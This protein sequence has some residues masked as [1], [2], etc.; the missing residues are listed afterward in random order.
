MMIT[1][2]LHLPGG[3]E[4]AVG[5]WRLGEVHEIQ[6]RPA[7]GG[8]ALSSRASVVRASAIAY[9]ATGHLLYSDAG[10]RPAE[11]WA[12]PISLPKVELRGEPLLVKRGAHGPSV[13]RDGTLVYLTLESAP[14]RLL[15]VSRGGA[16]LGHIGDSPGWISSPVLSS[17]GARVAFTGGGSRQESD[18]FVL[19]AGRAAATRLTVG[20]SAY[21]PTFSPTAD[22]LYYVDGSTDALFSLPLDG[23]AAGAPEPLPGGG[24]SYAPD[25][26]ADGRYLVFH[27]IDPVAGRDLWYVDAEAGGGASPYLEAPRDQLRPHISP[28]GRYVAYESDER[29]ERQIVV[30]TF[31]VRTGRWQISERDGRYPRW[32]PRGDEIFFVSGND[33]MAAPVTL[34]PAF[35]ARPPRRLFSGGDVAANLAYEG[36]TETE[37]AVAPDAERFLVVQTGEGRSDVVLVR[38]WDLEIEALAASR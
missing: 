1:S 6:I 37:Y 12:I 7:A 34:A 2:V 27:R 4:I 17:D 21:Q 3:R 31:P 32:S 19:G 22:R 24:R 14:D 26:S 20:G 11:L 13:A 25:W 16:P 10:I 38:N 23:N 5:V 9:S 36:S 33:L 29:D 28:D 8:E 35:E 30:E 15:W 18:L